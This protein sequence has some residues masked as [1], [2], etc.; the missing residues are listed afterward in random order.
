[1]ARNRCGVGGAAAHQVASGAASEE[2]SLREGRTR[3]AVVAT[4]RT[5]ALSTAYNITVR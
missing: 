2:I 3:V 5:G 1:M 4:D